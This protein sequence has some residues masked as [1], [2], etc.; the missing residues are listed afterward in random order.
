MHTALP[1]GRQALAPGIGSRLVGPQY[2]GLR[3]LAPPLAARR[4]APTLRCM[5]VRPGKGSVLQASESWAGG[6]QHDALAFRDCQ[7]ERRLPLIAA[8]FAGIGVH[9]WRMGAGAGRL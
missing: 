2:V 5:P 1:Q 6:A 4:A 9:A 7:F 3:R 8:L